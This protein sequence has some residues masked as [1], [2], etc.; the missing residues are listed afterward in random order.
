MNQADLGAPA[1]KCEGLP[2]SLPPRAVVTRKPCQFCTYQADQVVP[3]ADH[4]V[5]GGGCFA[6]YED[7]QMGCKATAYCCLIELFYEEDRHME[8]MKVRDL[9]V[10]AAKF[11]KISDSATFYEAVSALE[12]AQEKFL[13]GKS[14]QR[15]LLVKNEA[16]KVVGKISPIDLFRGLETSYSRVNAEETVRRFGLSYIWK[17]MQKDYSLWESPFKDLCR[18]ANGIHI[19]D[20]IKGPAEGQSVDTEDTLDKCFHLFVMNR[21]DTLFVF[22]GDEIVGLLRFS[23]VYRKV[24]QAM[25]ECILI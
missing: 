16:G 14:E 2:S 10:P 1:G 22:E 18:K 3:M 21:H 7:V 20:F 24:S 15:I 8:K 19:K 17:S 5:P 4:A 13:S 25:K 11:P 6:D 9:M 23:D 12:S